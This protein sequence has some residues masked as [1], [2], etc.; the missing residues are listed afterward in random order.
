MTKNLWKTPAH[1]LELDVCNHI[2]VEFKSLIDFEEP[3]PA[4]DHR[5]PGKLESLLGAVRQTFDG[6]YLNPTVL[7]AATAYFTQIIRDHPFENG[8]KRIAL[9]ITHVFLVVNQVEFTLTFEEMYQFAILTATAAQHNRDID[10]N[11]IKD[12]TKLI[13][14]D[15]TKDL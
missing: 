12:V 13:I 10:F 6:K 7:D 3:L 8:N 1:W 11:Q 2:F 15:F 5:F 9:L 4:F 14:Q